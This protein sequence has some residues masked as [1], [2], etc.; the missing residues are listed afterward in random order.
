MPKLIRIVSVLV[1]AA[2]L[3]LGSAQP[4]TADV[5]IRDGK[6]G[7]LYIRDEAPNLGQLERQ[8]AAF[9][10][11]NIGVEPKLEVSYN[12]PQAR[13]ALEQVMANSQTMDF[14]SI[15]GRAVGDIDISG[16][17]MSVR[18]EGVMAGFPATSINYHFIREG[19]LWKYDWKAICAEMQC[20][21]DPDFGY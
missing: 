1:F 6:A 18:V 14:F 12:G 13:G 10:N 15:Q 16:N 20:A 4:A 9:W 2:L 19:G 3:G 8:F 5:S 7:D 17:T 11:P 21:G